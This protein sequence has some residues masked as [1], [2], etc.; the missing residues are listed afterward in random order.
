ME[1]PVLPAANW[2]FSSVVKVNVC[3]DV[4]QNT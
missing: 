4:L 2:A 3:S 1:V